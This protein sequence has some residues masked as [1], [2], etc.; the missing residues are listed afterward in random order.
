VAIYLFVLGGLYMPMFQLWHSR[1]QLPAVLAAALVIGCLTP[2][3]VEAAPIKADIVFLIDTSGSMGDNINL[4]RAR[5]GDFNTAMLANNIDPLYSLVSFGNGNTEAL[6]VNNQAFAPFKVVLDGLIASGAVER[7]SEAVNLGLGGVSFRAGAHK[8]FI[9]ITDED[10]DSSDAQFLAADTGLG[11][12]GALFNFIGVPG[13]GN[14]DARYGVL[15]A[16]HGGAAFSIIDF[17]N[18]PD[19]FFENFTKT[20]VEEILQEVPEPASLALFGL[21]GMISGVYTL[22]RRRQLAA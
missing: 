4:V 7:G 10:D 9:L 12:A 16:N 22:R 15:A 11:D 5:I 6:L 18:D 19:P 20:K 17:Q 13:V 8:N 3:A 2:T 14:T 1:R 21:A